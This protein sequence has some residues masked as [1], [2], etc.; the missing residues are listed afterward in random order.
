MTSLINGA[1]QRRQ[2]VFPVEDLEIGDQFT[3]YAYTLHDGRVVYAKGNDHIVD[4]ARCAMLARECAN[5]DQVGE[6]TVSLLP[7]MTDPVSV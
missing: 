4:A 1:L 2:V 7:V 3:T 5:L 6:E